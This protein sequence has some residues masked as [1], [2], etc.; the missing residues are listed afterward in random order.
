MTDWRLPHASTPNPVCSWLH[1]NSVVARPRTS[2]SRSMLS[3]KGRWSIWATAGAS[4]A[5]ANKHHDELKWPRQHAS[6]NWFSQAAGVHSRDPCTR[7]RTAVEGR[8][9]GLNL[10]MLLGAAPCQTE[11]GTVSEREESSVA[12]SKGPPEVTTWNQPAGEIRMTDFEQISF[13]RILQD[14]RHHHHYQAHPRHGRLFPAS[15][16][17]LGNEPREAGI[18]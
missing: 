18:R 16:L 11:S 9:P 2:S 4:T 15:R 10:F 12:A 3:G 17:L 7:P 8:S 6:Q 5:Q 14:C 1:S 13:E